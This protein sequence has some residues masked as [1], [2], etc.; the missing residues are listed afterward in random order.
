MRFASVLHD[1]R[2]AAAAIVDDKAVPLDGIAELGA[3][4]PTELLRD[5]PLLEAAAVPLADVQLR[6]V[7]PRPSKL[8]CVGLNYHAHIEETQREVPDY[9]VLFT[10]FASS[11]TGPD[12]PILLPPESTQVDYEGELA[13]VI[14]STARRV[15]KDEALE[16]VAGYTLAND[17]SMRD[18]QF[19]THQWLQGKA[20]DLATPLG[21]HLVTS[22]EVP[23]P[24][25]LELRVTVNGDEVQRATTDL[26]IFDLATV[27]SMVSEFATLEPGDVILTGTPSGVGMARDP[28]LWLA[29]GDVVAVEIDGVGR[30]ESVARRESGGP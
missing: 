4:T 10:K 5:P 3:A 11:L 19:K 18:F 16:A 27:I 15:S 8:I 6:P 12:D 14:G 26:M 20:W 23:D 2:P 1:G 30:L 7:V 29:D 21:P 9:P 24:Q 22:D 28:Q 13:V 17:V 25:A